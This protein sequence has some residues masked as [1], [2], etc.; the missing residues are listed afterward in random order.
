M[1]HR[2]GTWSLRRV[3]PYEIGMSVTIGHTFLTLQ[4]L[5]NQISEIER[6]QSTKSGYIGDCSKKIKNN[7]LNLNNMQS[8]SAMIK[9]F[10]DE[11]SAKS[12]SLINLDNIISQHF[13]FRQQ[14][15]DEISYIEDSLKMSY[16]A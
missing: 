7:S 1:V 16:S 15:V 13:H 11:S 14:K 6:K 5:I 2:P 10:Q 4:M 8:G 9:R 12:T 3:I